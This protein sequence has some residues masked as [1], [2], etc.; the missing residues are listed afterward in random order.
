[1]T[2][3]RMSKWV[4]FL[5]LLLTCSFNS[6]CYSGKLANQTEDTDPGLDSLLYTVDSPAINNGLD[7]KVTIQNLRKGMAKPANIYFLS[8]SVSL[9]SAVTALNALN[10]YCTL[11]LDMDYT[12]VASVSFDPEVYIQ[13]T[14]GNVITAGESNLTG[15]KLAQD[16]GDFQVFNENGAGVVTFSRCPPTG[17]S[18]MWWGAAGDGTADDSDELNSA[19]AAVKAIHG[20]VRIGADI[21]HKITAQVD[22]SEVALIG[23][24]RGDEDSKGSKIWVSGG[25]TG[26]YAT[27][28]KSRL[29]NLNIWGDETYTGNL[30]GIDASSIGVYLYEGHEAKIKNCSFHRLETAV[31]VEGLAGTYDSYILENRFQFNTTNILATGGAAGITPNGMKLLYNT[32]VNGG[33]GTAIK[34]VGNYTV[35]PPE[36]GHRFSYAQ[37]VGNRIENFT[38]IFDVTLINQCQFINNEIETFT[39]LFSFATSQ[40]AD[41]IDCTWLSGGGMYPSLQMGALPTTTTPTAIKLRGYNHPGNLADIVADSTFTFLDYNNATETEL[42]TIGDADFSPLTSNYILWRFLSAGQGII[43][44]NSD[45]ETFRINKNGVMSFS[46]TPQAL[47]GAGTINVTT[48]ITNFT[49]TGVA[50]ALTIADGATQGQLKTVAMIGGEGAG[51]SGSLTGANVE[52][53]SIVMDANGEAAQLIWTNSKWF[54]NGGGATYI[55]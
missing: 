32:M 48:A 34:L 12:M 9:A 46:A 19:C 1:M 52:G 55:P 38:T 41:A 15:V 37:I 42:V 39:N 43:F 44:S 14:P 6:I 29:E 25:I 2:L 4:I 24:H 26:L 7:R 28:V 3:N 53:T 23:M 18:A 31:K 8:D 47:T 20:Q 17:V 22:Y 51:N 45:V 10:V 36:S 11:V 35:G 27:G 5:A 40:E 33:T 13:P 21:E 50:N 49:A 54:F 30:V 16:I